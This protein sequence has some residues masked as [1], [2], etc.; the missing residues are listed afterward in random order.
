MTVL[1]LELPKINGTNFEALWANRIHYF[2]YITTFILFAVFWDTH[3]TIFD[4]VEIVNSKIVKIQMFLL[5]LNT[6]FPYITSWVS[7]HPYS[8]LVECVYTFF[9][10]GANIVYSWLCD[11]LIK[12]DPENME[13]K[14]IITEMR[15]HKITTIFQIFSLIIGLVNPMFMLVVGFVSLSMW[16]VPLKKIKKKIK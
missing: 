4:K 14:N 10:L 3:H 6:L 8:Y 7:E 12:A 5:F 2:A 1:V 15:R 11:E 16:Y 9:L 13:L